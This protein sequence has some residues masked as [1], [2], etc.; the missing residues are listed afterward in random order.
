MPKLPPLV[1]LDVNETLLDMAG[2]DPVFEGAFGSAEWRTAWFQATLTLAMKNTDAGDYHDFGFTGRQALA[3]LAKERGQNV[4]A[5]FADKLSAAIQ[6]LPLHPD[7]PEGVQLLRAGGYRVGVLANNQAAVV[8]AQLRHVGLFN[9]LNV[10]LSAD[11]AR[12]LKPGQRAYEYALRET[13]A[14]VAETWMVAAHVWDIRGA[15]AAGLRGAYLSRLG[16]WPEDQTPAPEVRAATL[17]EAARAIL[18]LAPV[19]S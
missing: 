17:P 6:T 2:L 13:G 16:E 8:V 14:E 5:D 12:Q 9:S 7:V 1:L 4:P 15:V 11:N 10:V 3:A 19:P 18:S